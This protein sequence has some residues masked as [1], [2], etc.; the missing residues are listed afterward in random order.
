MSVHKGVG[1]L[2]PSQISELVW[3]S[4]SEEA[5]ALSD[6]IIY[7][8]NRILCIFR[9]QLKYLCFSYSFLDRIR[10]YHIEILDS[11]SWKAYWNVTQQTLVFLGSWGVTCEQRVVWREK[12]SVKCWGS[13]ICVCVVRWC[14]WHF[15]AK[16]LLHKSWS[17][18]FL[19]KL[20]AW[21]RYVSKIS[22]KLL[23]FLN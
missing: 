4:E 20:G 5:G 17:W 2:S 13:M 9:Q 1:F 22:W 3:D 7:L 14:F 6:I 19:C 8:G 16:A 21:N 18:N 12:L 11:L 15:H 23:K 10:K